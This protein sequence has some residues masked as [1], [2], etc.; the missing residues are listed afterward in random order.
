MKKYFWLKIVILLFVL[1][2]LIL[3][4]IPYLINLYLNANA[5]EIVSEMIT[6]TNDF[7]GHEVQFGEIQVNYDYRGTFLRLSDVK[8]QPGES[9]TGKNQIQ[10]NLTLDEA[11]L[12]GFRWGKFLFDNSIHLDSAH[13][14]NVNIESITPPLD[15]LDISDKSRAD[16]EG[17]DYDQVAVNR[18]SFNKVSF[19]NKDSYSDSTRLFIRDLFVFG[20]GFTLSKEDLENPEALF[21][22]DNIEGYMDQAVVHTNEFRNALYAKDLSFNTSEE[23]ID[24]GQI[25]I[26]NKL[27]RYEYMDQFEKETDWI[28]LERGSVTL[29]GMDFQSYFREG[30]LKVRELRVNDM[31]L[32]VFRDKRKPD[33]LDHRPKMVHTILRDLPIELDIQKVNIN[34]GYV[35]YEERPENDAPRSGLIFFDNV[36]ASIT[37]MTNARE[38]LE[39]S[40][41]MI[42]EAQGRLIG[43]GMIDLKVNY[44]LNDTTGK[45]NMEG[46]IGSMD[47]AGLNDIIEPSTKVSLKQGKVNNVFF[48]LSANDKEGAGDLIVK[49]EDLEIEILDKDFGHDQNIFQKIGSF[50]ANKLVIKSSNPDKKGELKE[51]D[52]YYLKKPQNSIFKYWWELVLSGLKSTLTG[53]SEQDLRRKAKNN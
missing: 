53:D 24:I 3:R 19:Q 31:R 7:G 44:F 21:R 37:G 25:I 34:N 9:I 2:L 12:T 23:K 41:E 1:V 6:R 33:N 49:Y 20:D 46:S 47:L 28:E 8:I 48:N 35:S 17:K 22:V 40:D 30:A 51:A 26:E 15:S 32:V 39:K 5:E 45:F 13:I 27:E 16:Q 36:E 14:Q 10:F 43:Q 29:E 4:G 52:I 42:L 18:I 11:S 50:L 38:Q